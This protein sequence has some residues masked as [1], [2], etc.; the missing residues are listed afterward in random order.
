MTTNDIQK[1]RRQLMEWTEYPLAQ[2]CL[3][4]IDTLSSVARTFLYVAVAAV[5]VALAQFVVILL[6]VV[7]RAL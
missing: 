1:L 4:A 7:S 3:D 5:V 2:D 6:W